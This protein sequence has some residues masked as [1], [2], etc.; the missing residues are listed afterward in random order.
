MVFA[1]PYY[2]TNQQGG[3]QMISKSGYNHS[4]EI[5]IQDTIRV[6]CANIN[7][8]EGY[9]WNCL[10]FDD[11]ASG[12]EYYKVTESEFKTYVLNAMDSVIQANQ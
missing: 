8:I 10:L 6:Q 4:I 5:D 9:V 12:A 11:G 2:N 3:T 7:D 1:L